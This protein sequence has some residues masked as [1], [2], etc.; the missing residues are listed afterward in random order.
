MAS[1]ANLGSG[2][3]TN[4]AA[5]E[6]KQ[7]TDA[8]LAQAIGGSGDLTKSGAGTLTLSGEN[9]STGGTRIEAGRLIAAAGHLG[10]GAIVNNA[11]LEL[12]QALD[13]TLAQ[14]LAG[15][16]QL[17]KSGAGTL[18]LTST[19]T[20]TG[21]T[22]IEAGRLVASVANLGSGA[23]TN[24]AALELNQAGDA[25][26]AQA[27]AGNGSLTK[28]GAGTLA[29]TGNGS[30]YTGSTAVDAGTLAIGAGAVLGGSLHVAGGA[31]LTGSGSVGS[32]TLASGAIIAPGSTSASGHSYGTLTVNGDLRFAPGSTYQFHADPDSGTSDRLQVSGT[33]QLAGGLLHVGPGAGFDVSKTYTLLQAASLQGQFD[34]VSSNYAYLDPK[35]Q[36]NA[37][38]LSLLLER[39]QLPVDP[40]DPGTA[41]RPIEFADLAQT[42]NQTGVANAVQSL[43]PDSALYRFV[44]SLPEGTPAAVFESLSGEVHSTA[45]GSMR[46]GAQLFGNSSLRHLHSNLTANLRPGAPIAQSDGPLPASAWPSTKALPM[47]AEVVGHWQSYA[48]DGNAARLKQS[49]GG[50]FLGGDGEVAG[51][52]WRVGGSLGYTRTDARVADRS[53]TGKV[54][55]YSAAV[56]GGKSFG[57]GVGQLNVMGG[58]AYTW[59]E[60]ASERHVAALEQTLKADYHAGTSQLFAEVG[61]A[62]GQYGKVGI[63]PF[64]GISLGEQ[65]TRGF[66]ERGG[67]AALRG[68]A[69]RDDLGSG[70]L[71]LR[72]H[73]D[74]KLGGSE[75]RLR[76]TLGW[77][78]AFGDVS[79]RTS[80]AFEGGQNFTVAGVPLAR[81]TALLGLEAELELSRNAA[82]VLGYKGEFGSGNRDHSAQVRVRWAF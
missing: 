24:N 25:T 23:I 77:R 13:A 16:G 74:F 36:Y 46:S 41:T 47:W 30:A 12:N 65:R 31:S 20:S 38:S 26:L 9:T 27:L 32:T 71:G 56:Y 73:S 66:Q 67:F 53:S 51:S 6:L 61:Y 42:R 2:A 8:T 34:T 57:A 59:H 15:S 62:L 81:N 39:K 52:G 37:N 18:T 75:G 21:G 29:F 49:T 79:N 1:A 7:P 22:V 44:Q 11:T 28:T 54:D 4:N 3:I 43:Q 82:L 14:S 17:V 5:L 33:V 55:S 78:H 19:N 63:E 45:Q 72:M 40:A 80:M 50:L 68:D 70:T 76:G 48:G 64:A 35:L 69:S 10:R 58:L 60:I